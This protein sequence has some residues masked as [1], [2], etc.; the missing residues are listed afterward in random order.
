MSGPTLADDQSDALRAWL[1]AIP[2]PQVQSSAPADAILRGKDLFEGAAGCSGCHTGPRLTS[3]A[4]VDV[5]TGGAFQVPPLVGVS[6]RA[7][8]LHS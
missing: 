4:T 3:N 6:L 5:G 1:F 2:R 8:Y 7:P